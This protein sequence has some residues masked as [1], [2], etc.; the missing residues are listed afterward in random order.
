[1]IARHRIVLPATWLR[2]VVLASALTAHGAATGAA[3]NA[4]QLAAL[5]LL[6]AVPWAVACLLSTTPAHALAE[7]PADVD[8]RD[9]VDSD[10]L[11][12]VARRT[13]YSVTIGDSQRRLAWVNGSFTRLTGYT[14]EEAIGRHTSELPYFERTDPGIVARVKESFAARRGE[15]R[16]ERMARHRCTSAPR[17]SRRAA[18]LGE[19]EDLL[20]GRG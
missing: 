6:F 5:V 9:A 12:P 14:A 18:R 10:W 11:A 4:L 13:G 8:T 19:I 3:W 17:S 2:S 20:R 1:M 7:V 16:S 15:G